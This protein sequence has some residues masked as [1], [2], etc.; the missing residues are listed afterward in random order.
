MGEKDELVTTRDSWRASHPLC[1]TTS[2]ERRHR[3][4]VCGLNVQN[5]LKCLR[6]CS[7]PCN[8][9]LRFFLNVKTWMKFATTRHWRR[10]RGIV[11]FAGSERERERDYSLVWYVGRP[12]VIKPWLRR[13][14]DEKKNPLG[15]LLVFLTCNVLHLVLHEQEGKEKHPTRKKKQER[16]GGWGKVPRRGGGRE[17]RRH[18]KGNGWRRA[19]V[20]G[21][22]YSSKFG[23]KN[24]T[25]FIKR[26]F[27]FIVV[28]DACLTSSWILRLL[29]PKSL[30]IDSLPASFI[31][32]LWDKKYEGVRRRGWG[33][34]RKQ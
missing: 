34:W 17:R 10:R 19:I 20:P 23:H 28:L 13:L 25:C 15:C 14:W 4:P 29:C 2:A 12:V 32:F 8:F 33:E 3:I 31:K 22:N 5:V 30:G 6:R 24:V 18:M 21:Q 1:A 16:E 26:D 7:S 11:Y 27:G 9:L